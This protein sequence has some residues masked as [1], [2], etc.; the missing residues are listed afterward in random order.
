MLVLSIFP[1]LLTLSSDRGI[2]PEICLAV[3]SLSDVAIIA[4]HLQIRT[5]EPEIPMAAKRLDVIRNDPH[6]RWFSSTTF[7]NT[8]TL[9][10]YIERKA[11]PFQ[12]FIKRLDVSF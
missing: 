4:Q 10:F 3:R 8:T 5:F 11:L 12:R 7:A 9:L 2:R 1:W 6:L